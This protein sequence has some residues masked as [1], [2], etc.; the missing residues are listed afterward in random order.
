MART[1]TRQSR[2]ATAD[3]PGR[4][5]RRKAPASAANGSATSGRPLKK[6]SAPAPKGASRTGAARTAPKAA[7]RNGSARAAGGRGSAR[8]ETDAVRAYLE[9]LSSSTPGRR[10]RPEPIRKRIAELEA[11]LEEAGSIKRLTLLQRLVDL[12]RELGEA[13]T[14]AGANGVAAEAEERFV[15]VAASFARRKGITWVAWRQFGV[16]AATLRKAGVPR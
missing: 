8:A 15:A 6:L 3:Q 1:S 10:R 2:T 11:Q 4:R 14:A 5:A 13:E 9:V 16:T 7:S 12:R